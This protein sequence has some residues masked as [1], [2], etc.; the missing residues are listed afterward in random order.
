MNPR[1]TTL[2]GHLRLQGMYQYYVIS[3][4]V[5]AL[6]RVKLETVPNEKGLGNRC[7]I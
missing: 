6:F 5:K 3:F 7:T 4:R 1:R 2:E